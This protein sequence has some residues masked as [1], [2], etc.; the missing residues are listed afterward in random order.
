MSDSAGICRPSGRCASF[1]SPT[2]T[3]IVRSSEWRSRLRARGGPGCAAPSTAA[4][5]SR[6]S[7]TP[8]SITIGGDLWEDEHVTPDT[9]RWV[10]DRLARAGRPVIIVAGNHDPLSPGGPFDRA[11][12][13]ENVKVLGSAAALARVDV[14][15][16]SVWGTSWQRA[17]RTHEPGAE[18]LR[19]AGRRSPARAAAPRH[20]RWI[21]RRRV[22]LPVHQPRTS[23][24]AGF[25][26]CLAGHLHGG[27]VRDGI[28][29]Y[30]G[31]PE[32]LTWSEDGRH[33]AAVIDLPHAGAPEVE[34][35]DVN[36]TRYAVR[37]VDVTRR[38][39]QCRRRAAAM[40]VLTACRTRRRP[41]SSAGA[42][43]SCRA[44]LPA[45]GPERPRSAP[46]HRPRIGR[47]ARPDQARV[48]SRRARRGHGRASCVRDADARAPA[49][50]G[51][52]AELAL[53]L[54]LRALE[55]E[56]L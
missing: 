2:S 11:P 20:V 44:R 6:R 3:S 51:D 9:I 7:A 26:L 24:G 22:P 42:R 4:S 50:D 5:S 30:P 1:T 40:Q 54:G 34:L 48:R 55:G 46:G 12:F 31:S 27:G 33:T 47:R 56:A 38:R 17:T 16:L 53:Y 41:A 52:I 25:D 18:W 37:R 32:P 39:V 35:V 19:R 45:V 36:A 15:D 43:G 8:I 14:G 21:L 29:V 13:G 10:A 23:V 28:V 49:A